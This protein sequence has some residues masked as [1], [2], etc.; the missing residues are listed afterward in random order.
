MRNHLLRTTMF[1]APEGTGA[2]NGG[3]EHAPAVPVTPTSEPVATPVAEASAPTAH[4]TPAAAPAVESAP[5]EAA[6]LVGEA[7]D[8]TKPAESEKSAAAPTASLLSAPPKPDAKSDAKLEDKPAEG[9]PPAEAKPTYEPFTL[10]EGMKADDALM[11]KFTD[12]AGT[13]KLTQEQAQAF[14]SLGTEAIN[15]AVKAASDHMLNEQWRQHNEMR[16]GW[17]DEIRKDPIIGGNKFDTSLTNARKMVELLVPKERQQAFDQMLT[18]TGAGD[19]PE[20]HRFM[21]SI[22]QW[23]NEPIAPKPA[24]KPAKSNG[25]APG[26]RGLRSMYEK[27]AQ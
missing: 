18:I 1:F 7:P 2:G 25:K 10:P 17:V 14:M 11:G 23:L 9:T 19:H 24:A 3:A 16:Q 26:P 12:L 21:H 15:S 8:P 27:A 4:E 6:T 13:Q 22:G 20:F 5:A